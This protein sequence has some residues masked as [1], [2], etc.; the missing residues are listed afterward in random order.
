MHSAKIPCPWPLLFSIP[1]TEHT[2]GAGL[3]RVAGAIGK[4]QSS[5][6]PS[7]STSHIK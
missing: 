6:S 2:L 1:F 3:L 5:V 7:R 4:E